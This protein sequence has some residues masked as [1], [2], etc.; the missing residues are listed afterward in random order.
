MTFPAPSDVHSLYSC[1]DG[2]CHPASTF[3]T[4]VMP[5]LAAAGM[6]FLVILIALGLVKVIIEV[7]KWL[8]V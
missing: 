7:V 2:L 5:V 1:Y 8:G 6:V 4:H 3:V